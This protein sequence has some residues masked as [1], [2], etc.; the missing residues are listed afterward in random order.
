MHGKW[1]CDGVP[2]NND[3]AYYGSGPHAP[4]ENYGPD[5]AI[6]GLP[7]EAMLGQSKTPTTLISGPNN[8]GG[9]KPTRAIAILPIIVGVVALIV[10]LFPRQNP[11]LVSYKNNEYQLNLKY[12]KNWQAKDVGN[13]NPILGTEVVKFLPRE[14]DGDTLHLTLNIEEISSE[15]STIEEF[16]DRAIEQI[17]KYSQ[18]RIIEKGQTTL[19]G[20]PAYYIVFAGDSGQ[21]NLKKRQ[22]FAQKS[23]GEFYVLTYTAEADKYDEFFND[24]QA[25]IKSFEF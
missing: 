21:E 24:A 2:K 1:T 23:D 11:D 16:R 25:I 5:C 13:K 18:Y 12:P 8:W 14:N 15:P 17:R 3:G 6:C 9:Q 10:W 4:C 7:R 19:G 22:V 20:E